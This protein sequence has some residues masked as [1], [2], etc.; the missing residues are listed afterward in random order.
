[1]TAV[2][3]QD[4]TERA[5]QP[6]DADKAGAADPPSKASGNARDRL[7]E[8]LS[9]RLR[10]R[11]R[12]R[13]A[14]PRARAGRRLLLPLG[15]PRADPRTDS[16]TDPRTDSCGTW[17]NSL[18][19]RR[20]DETAGGNRV[21]RDGQPYRRRRCPR[22]C[23]TGRCTTGWRRCANWWGSPAPGSTA[24]RWRRRAGC[25]TRRPRGAGSPGSTPSSPSRA[26]RAAASHSC[27]T[28]SPGWPSWRPVCRRPL[29]VCSSS[30]G[31][32]DLIERLGIPPGC[33][34]V[35]LPT[36]D[37]D[38]QLRGL[39]LIDLPDHDS[40]AVQ[41]RERVDRILALVDAVIWVVDPEKYADA[42]LHE[43][44]LRP[45]AGHAEV[46]F[47]VLNQTDRLP[48]RR[49]RPRPRRP[50]APPRR[51]R[52]RPRRTATAPTRRAPSLVACPRSPATGS[53]ELRWA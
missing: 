39:V 35:Q 50:P 42:V 52:H 24:G 8:R 32:A 15:I 4:H 30:D 20:V 19:A 1:M 16:R 7:R 33:A 37:G 44:Y 10:G 47:V 13:C 34:G 5:D 25:S 12:G 48:A 41:H 3:D 27:S 38:S 29:R 45:L 43:R 21:R 46:M 18:I 14:G 22:W 53:P 26:P 28:Q 31:A 23:T 51:G 17:D 9:E 40:A 36:G 6:G 2:T 11:E 49:R